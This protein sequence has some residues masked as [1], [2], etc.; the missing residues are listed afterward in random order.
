M[1]CC[2]VNCNF[3]PGF[4]K[5]RGK[6]MLRNL[7]YPTLEEFGYVL[8]ESDLQTKINNRFGLSCITAISICLYLT[9]EEAI[10]TASVRAEWKPF[11]ETQ[12]DSTER[13]ALRKM[14]RKRPRGEIHDCHICLSPCEKPT[15][16]ECDHTF[17]YTCIRKWIGI[18]KSCPVCDSEINVQKYVRKKRVK[19]RDKKTFPI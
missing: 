13:K 4:P 17:C 12:L 19:L 15:T 9:D 16:I 2:I 10:K 6:N 11:E 7:I 14:S 5:W 1:H 18:K 8:P 3:P